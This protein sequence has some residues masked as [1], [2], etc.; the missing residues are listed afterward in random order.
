MPYKFY[1]RLDKNNGCV[2]IIKVP[3]NMEYDNILNCIPI[4]DED[5]SILNKRYNDGIWEDVD[6]MYFYRPLS[7]QETAT[8]QMQS[9]LEYLVCLKELGL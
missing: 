8:L 9:D 7:E 3:I 2:S 4:Q 1:A 5:D 6:P